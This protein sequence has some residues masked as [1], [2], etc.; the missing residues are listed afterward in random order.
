MFR[1]PILIATLVLSSAVFAQQTVEKNATEPNDKLRKDAVVFL[2]ETLTDVNGM[3]SLENR[4]SFAAELAGLMWFYDEREA[5]AM[6]TG[7]IGDF[8]D[9]IRKYDSQMNE[10]G[11]TLKDEESGSRFP[12]FLIEP[13]DGSRLLRKFTTAMGVRQQIAL[14]IAEHDA[15][16]AFTFYNDSLLA[17]ANPELRAQA[18]DRDDH[19]VFQLLG[20]LAETDP[21]KAVHYG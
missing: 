20:E 8:K 4:I 13:T 16:L 1:S 2:R 10:L 12:S 14:S 18:S 5:R 7:V 3:R 17:I 21:G 19:F 15:D 9:L 11:V 6:Y